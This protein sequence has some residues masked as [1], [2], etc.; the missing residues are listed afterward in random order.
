ML[1]TNLQSEKA[2]W[3]A[4]RALFASDKLAEAMEC[5][6]RGLTVN[7]KNKVFATLK[8][9]IERSRLKEED[10]R[11]RER[12]EKAMS[13][14]LK[15]AFEIRGLVI[16][17]SPTLPRK[18]GPKFAPQ[19]KYGSD[20]DSDADYSSGDDYD[21]DD[22][23]PLAGLKATKWQAPDLQTQL[24]FTVYFNYPGYNTMELVLDYWEDRLVGEYLDVKFP[25][26]GVSK[27]TTMAKYWDFNDHFINPN[28]NVYAQ[29]HQ[30][31]IL[32]VSRKQ[33]LRQIMVQ[34]ADI[35][36]EEGE[37]D[38]LVLADG[39]LWLHL[40]P[41]GSAAE[42]DWLDEVKRERAR[43]LALL[44]TLGDDESTRVDV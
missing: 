10:A 23:F 39:S 38:G 29:T 22:E 6:D 18:P 26:P 27:E 30:L 37:R 25:G 19:D 24:I 44:M 43:C 8:A 2:Y 13:A 36:G 4:A 28:I 40:V 12:R 31:R 16:K 35:V 20:Y 17:D 21:S 9:K 33:S 34:C 14:A 15:R 7:P 32:K 11:E 41:A 42:R 1:R 5:C 3:R